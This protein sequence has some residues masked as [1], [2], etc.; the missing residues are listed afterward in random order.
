MVI[1]TLWK[2]FWDPWGTLIGIQ[3][4]WDILFWIQGMLLDPLCL[5][6]IWN[7]SDNVKDWN[8]LEMWDLCSW[9]QVLIPFNIFEDNFWSE[10]PLIVD[11]LEWNLTVIID[12]SLDR[13]NFNGFFQCY[14]SLVFDLAAEAGV[15]KAWTIDK[16][17][18]S[19]SFCQSVSYIYIINHLCI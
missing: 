16:C 6:R 10:S 19:M 1:W 5:Y 8:I 3:R 13:F 17:R 9:T 4:S 12:P 2:T 11:L 7:K 14:S 18:L 15:G